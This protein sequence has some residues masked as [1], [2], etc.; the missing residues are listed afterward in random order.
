MLLK[1]LLKKKKASSLILIFFLL[2]YAHGIIFSTCQIETSYI[3]VYKTGGL[4][5]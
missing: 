3:Y 1:R 5:H 4:N 2:P